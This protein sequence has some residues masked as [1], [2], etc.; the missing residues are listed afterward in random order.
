M[1]YDLQQNF[2]ISSQTNIWTEYFKTIIT[3]EIELRHFS[4]FQQYSLLCFNQCYS[5]DFFSMKIMFWHVMFIFRRTDD[6]IISARH[7]LDMISVTSKL[8]SC[9]SNHTILWHG[10][11]LK[12]VNSS[13]TWI[14]VCRGR[15]MGRVP[16]VGIPFSFF[17]TNF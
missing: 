17:Q 12:C 1:M 14:V 9:Y 2:L 5:F 13:M 11:M 15:F 16:G 8:W 3:I 4:L 6:I 10:F 7:D